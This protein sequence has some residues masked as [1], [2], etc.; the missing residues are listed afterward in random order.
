MFGLQMILSL[1]AAT[2]LR[3][4]RIAAAAATWISNPLTYFPLYGFGFQ[5]GRALLGYG[6]LTFPKEGIPS[7]NHLSSLG[8]DFLAALFFGCVVLGVC[9]SFCSYWAC[10]HAI[11]RARRNKKQGRRH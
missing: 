4:Y 11:R 2:L 7:L 10:L 5:V 9:F 1:A 8:G 3:G 6:H